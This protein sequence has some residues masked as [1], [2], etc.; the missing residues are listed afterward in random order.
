MIISCG[1]ALVDLVPQPVPGGGPMNVAVAAARLGAKAAFVGRVSEDPHGDL[2]WRH[3]VDN[4]VELCAA[5]RGPEPTARAIVDET[6]GL[7]FRFEGD[8]TADT[9]L[10][11]ADLDCLGPEPHIVHGGTLG[12]FRGPTA[13]TLARLVEGRHGIVSLDPNVRPQ[14]I[15]DRAEWDHFHDRWLAHTHLY[16]ASAEDLAWVW[17]GRSIESIAG[18]LLDGPAGA[19]AVTL[20]GDGAALFTPAGETRIAGRD[21]VVADTVGAGDTFVASL[22]VS[23]S[24]RGCATP[25]ELAALTVADWSE[26]GHAAVAAAAITCTRQGADPPRAAELSAGLD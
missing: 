15:P 17:P 5:Q 4:D 1:E 24:V 8:G 12:L 20:G 18:E 2:I 7:S 10:R 16:K 6:D 22:L 11:R 25:I 3:L 9:Q 23:L 21:V 26:M 19:V 14:M 13:E